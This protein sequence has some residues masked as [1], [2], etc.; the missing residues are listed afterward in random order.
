MAKKGLEND[1]ERKR[2]SVQ[3]RMGKNLAYEDL[4]QIIGNLQSKLDDYRQIEANSRTIFNE[5]KQVAEETE[6]RHLSL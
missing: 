3:R 5:F 6:K 1:V 2:L 4:E